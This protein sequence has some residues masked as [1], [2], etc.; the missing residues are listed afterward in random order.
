ME[1]EILS[2]TFLLDERGRL[3]AEGWA[4]DDLVD[5][6]KENIRTRRSLAEWEQYHVFNREFSLTITYGHAGSRGMTTAVLTDLLTGE[7]TVFGR[8][9]SCPGD[10]FDLDHNSGTPHNLKQEEGSFFLSIGF[11]GELRSIQVRD[12][13]LHAELYV[14]ETGRPL[15][16]VTPFVSRRNFSMSYRRT[17][18]DLAGKITFRNREYTLT[19]DTFLTLWSLRAVLP[20]RMEWI[21]AVGTQEIDGSVY[22]LQLLQTDG[23]EDAPTDCALFENGT[24]VKLGELRCRMNDE[25]G[26]K[27]LYLSDSSGRVHLTFEPE[28]ENYV[29]HF[30]SL[31]GQKKRR[32]FGTVSGSVVNGAGRKIAVSDMPFY[33]EKAKH[34]W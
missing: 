25:K 21:S 9:V 19:G 16:T 15:V 34:R 5:Y 31:W 24:I 14:H 13:D 26:L 30:H 28:Y 23:E 29:N 6:N 17:F 10:R 12:E 18:T 4:A 32:L 20:R 7:V 2:R 3:C 8:D 27:T 33:M 1:K 11:D 22:G